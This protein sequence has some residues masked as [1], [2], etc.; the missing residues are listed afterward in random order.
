MRLAWGLL[1]VGAALFALGFVLRA[2][3]ESDPVEGVGT[4]V[5]MVGV[6]AAAVGAARVMRRRG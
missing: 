3:S 5:T 2:A 4:V 6:L 1:I